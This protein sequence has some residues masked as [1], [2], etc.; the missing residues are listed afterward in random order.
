MNKYAGADWIEKE[1]S[2]RDP[3]MKLSPLGKAVAD[4]LGE[5]MYG[6]YH[7]N[8]KSLYKVDWSNNHYIEISIYCSALSTCDYNDLTRLVFLAHHM[9]IRIQLEPSTHH[10]MRMMFH[11]RTRGGHGQYHPTLDT[12]VSLFKQ[13]VSIPECVGGDNE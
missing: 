5:W 12:A 11:Q 1:M 13:T 8:Y 7:L 4:L 6:I 10:H 2:Y 9:A 3:E